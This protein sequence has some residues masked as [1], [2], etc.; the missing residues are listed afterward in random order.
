M[1]NN[2]DFATPVALESEAVRTQ[3]YKRTYGSLA[4][5][6]LLFVIFEAVLLN[7]PLVVD[8]MM[9]FMVDTKYAWLMILGAFMG[10][11]YI[12]Q[13]LAYNSAS[14][15]KQYAGYALYILAQAFLFVPLIV[16]AVSK[17]GD[18][19]LVSQAGVMTL[20]LFGG[21]TGVVFAT[22]ANF[23][24]LRSIIT[25]GSFLALGV[26]VAGILFG[27]SIGLWFSFAM[28]ALASAAILYDTWQVKNKFAADQY[29]AASLSL[30]ASLMLLLW[31]ILNILTG[32]NN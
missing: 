2:L 3:F 4:L 22:N 13:N 23:S 9:S 30:F 15:P 21:L 24:I 14:K 27:F 12:A 11:S 28:V 17:T 6:V 25:I 19:S 7:T 8:G 20:A 31:Y 29:V 16:I 1:E 26:I 5:G 32:R 10:V 18:F